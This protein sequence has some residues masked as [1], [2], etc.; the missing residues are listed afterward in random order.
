[1]NKPEVLDGLMVL[2]LGVST[3]CVILGETL[4]DLHVLA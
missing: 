3:I 4:N 2:I 1:M